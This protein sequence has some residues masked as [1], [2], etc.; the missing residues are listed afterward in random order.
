MS[1]TVLYSNVETLDEADVFHE[2]CRAKL[3]ELGFKTIE[4]AALSAMRECCKDDPKQIID[5]NS[6]V[7]IVS[8]VYMSWLLFT[9]FPNESGARREEIVLRFES[10]DALTS[11]HTRM[12]FWGTAGIAYYNLASEWS[13][14]EFP[15][16]LVEAAI[17]RASD[18]AAILE[19]LGKIESILGELPRINGD[20]TAAVLS[21]TD[22]IRIVETMV[23]LFSAKTGLECE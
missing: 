17:K 19:E 6:A 16:D 20:P 14:T 8:E 23:K 5:A 9:F 11:L 2:L 13:G 3:D 4:A 10:S 1:H 15:T 22:Q 18:G 7:V 12:G 21:E